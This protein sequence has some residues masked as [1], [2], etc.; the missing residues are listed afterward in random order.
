M[1]TGIEDLEWDLQSGWSSWIT[2]KFILLDALSNSFS[3]FIH[4]S[5]E[6]LCLSVLIGAVP[7]YRT[8]GLQCTHEGTVRAAQLCPQYA[9]FSS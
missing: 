2:Y 7:G 6:S 8:A 5:S 3:A 4:E 9:P 1:Q